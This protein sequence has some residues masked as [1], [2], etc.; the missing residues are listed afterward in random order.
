MYA[1]D[2]NPLNNW[3]FFAKDF[4]NHIGTVNSFAADVVGSL[5][6]RETDHIWQ[7]GLSDWAKVDG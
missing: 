5:F 1:L 3:N 2:G 4:T 7:T 6:A